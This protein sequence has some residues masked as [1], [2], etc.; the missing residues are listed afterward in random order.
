[1]IINGSCGQII[2]TKEVYIHDDILL[3]LEF[4][5]IQKRLTLTLKKY[6]AENCYTI[7]FA[8]VIGFHMS[9]CDFWGASECV[10]DFEYVN[11]DERVIVAELQEKWLSVPNAP[12]NVSYD[13]HIET[14]LT[15]SSGDQLRVA[16]ETIEIVT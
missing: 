15:F 2:N 11:P 10:L 3:S 14:L 5:R 9:S 16:C 1:M 8:D 6:A 7:T 13:Q 12:K 4:E